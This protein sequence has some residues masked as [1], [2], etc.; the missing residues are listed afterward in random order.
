MNIDSNFLSM[1]ATELLK[2]LADPAVLFV[3][4]HIAK[5]RQ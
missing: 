4:V 2:I 3:D 1:T 5:F